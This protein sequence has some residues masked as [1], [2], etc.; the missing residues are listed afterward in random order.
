MLE[1]V[2]TIVAVIEIQFITRIYRCEII[3]AMAFI[4]I[5]PSFLSSTIYLLVSAILAILNAPSSPIDYAY[6]SHKCTFPFIV[7]HRVLSAYYL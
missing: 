4:R 2:I 5:Y 7:E 1:N 3:M 6:M